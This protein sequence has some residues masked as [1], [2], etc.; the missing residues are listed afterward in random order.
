VFRTRCWVV[1][2]PLALGVLDSLVTGAEATLEV[3]DVFRLPM[4][5]V[6]LGSREG[7]SLTFLRL[8]GFLS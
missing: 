4:A 6:P 7:R 8:E 2:V 5:V 1:I 3:G